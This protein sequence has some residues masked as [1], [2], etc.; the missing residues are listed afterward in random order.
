MDD[1]KQMWRWAD[2][3]SCQMPR[4]PLLHLLCNSL[5]E[6]LERVRRPDGS[7]GMALVLPALTDCRWWFESLLVDS[8]VSSATRRKATGADQKKM[9]MLERVVNVIDPDLVKKELSNCQICRTSSATFDIGQNIFVS[10]QG[11]KFHVTRCCRTFRS[12]PVTE[13]GKCTACGTP[14]HSMRG[15]VLRQQR[16]ASSSAGMPED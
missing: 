16:A 8:G 1:T 2:V 11:Q 3:G 6:M 4:V 5:F 15:S 13:Y 10:E 14:E 7:V 9:E 12:L